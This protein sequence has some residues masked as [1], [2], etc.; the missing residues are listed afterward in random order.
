MI[1]IPLEYIGT[2]PTSAE[3]MINLRYDISSVVDLIK[4]NRAKGNLLQL[5]DPA[6]L[7]D[8]KNTEF[9]VGLSFI[10]GE[11]R[12]KQYREW[13]L[14]DGYTPKPE[15]A[16]AIKDLDGF[17]EVDNPVPWRA[18]RPRPLEAIWATAPF[19]HNGSVPSIY[20]LL[21]PADE[22]D[23]EFYLGRKEFNPETLGF[24]VGKFKG[25]FKFDTALKGNSNLGHEFNDGLCGNG[26]IGYQI[27]DKPGY[28]RQFTEYERLALIEYLKTHN[29]GKRP[30]PESAPH[31]INAEWPNTRG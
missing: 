3:N 10:G 6:T 21:L 13:G 25:A 28:C 1:H 8:P 7:P 20:Q 24:E 29:D 18:Y 26:V 23:Q 11:V 14:M 30:D 5:P 31:C 27:K 22:R 4:E 17:G 12:Y 16:D 15:H 9:A 2:D 19:L